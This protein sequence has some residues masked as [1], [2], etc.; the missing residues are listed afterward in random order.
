MELEFS[1]KIFKTFWNIKFQ[2]KSI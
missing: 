1:Q 2:E